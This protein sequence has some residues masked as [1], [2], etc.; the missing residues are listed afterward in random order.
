MNAKKAEFKEFAKKVT[1]ARKDEE[2]PIDKYR[3]KTAAKIARASKLK[4]M[5]KVSL[6][7]NR[8]VAELMLDTSYESLYKHG[9]RS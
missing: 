2:I 7:I 4:Q 8:N 1:E 5:G 6:N 9:Y 3:I